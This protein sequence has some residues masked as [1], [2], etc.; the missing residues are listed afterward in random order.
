MADVL[1]GEEL[2][3]EEVLG[4]LPLHVVEHLGRGFSAVVTFTSISACMD[5]NAREKLMSNCTF[6]VTT[7]E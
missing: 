6:S 7:T 2:E 3:V 5:Q 1:R 4:E